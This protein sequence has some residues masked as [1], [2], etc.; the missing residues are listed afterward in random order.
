MASQPLDG[1]KCVEVAYF[2]CR[3]HAYND[4]RQPRVVKVLLFE[5]E[6]DNCEDRMAVAVIKSC[7][8]VG[9]VPRHLS[10]LFSQ[11]RRGACNKAVVIAQTLG[12]GGKQRGT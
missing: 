7:T 12:G 3:Y 5:C 1:S 6:P 4:I 11:F 10:T 8:V 2:I 9:R